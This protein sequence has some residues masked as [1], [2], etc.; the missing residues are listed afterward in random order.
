MRIAVIGASGRT[1]AH[2]MEQ[3]TDLGHRMRAVV[4]D[5]DK[6]ST[7]L[8]DDIEDASEVV[9]ADVRDEAALLRALEDVDGVVF[10]V[11][12]A[13]D[14]TGRILREGMRS[15]LA[16]ME[17]VGVSRIVAVSAS[18]H[19]SDGDDP[20]ARFLAKPLLRRL[21]GR[22]FADM[23]AM[24]DLLRSSGADWTVIRPPRLTNWPER[25]YVERHD[26]NV[27]WKWMVSR[28]DLAAAILDAMEDEAK[29]GVTISI[30]T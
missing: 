7:V 16:A 4:R 3:G 30:A 15:C 19:T 20:F 9:E 8:D 27:R 13:G 1:G 5:P 6:L 17:L 10:C 25:G 23:R 12:T 22:A 21:L 24:E 2:V 29:V 26:G 18:G 11:S 28:A 14:P